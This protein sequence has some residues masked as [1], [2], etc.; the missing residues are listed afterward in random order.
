MKTF[1]QKIKWLSPGKWELSWYQNQ[2]TP[3][4]KEPQPVRHTRKT[5]QRGAERF[6]NRHGIE[7]IKD[8]HS[9]RKKETPSERRRRYYLHSKLRNQGFEVDAY[10]KQIE[11]GLGAKVG[12]VGEL[13]SLGYN[14]QLRMLVNDGETIKAKISTT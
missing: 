2:M 10:K 11:V 7:F 1:G 6:C 3:G 5:D 8:T 14:A 13:V 9:G 4:N 12:D